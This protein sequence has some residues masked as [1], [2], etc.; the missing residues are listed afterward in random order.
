MKPRNFVR[1]EFPSFPANVGLARIAI[2]TFATQLEF[3][4]GELE[5]IRV[6]VSEAVSNCVIH[7]YPDSPG[8]VELEA[9][10]EDGCLEIGITDYGKGIDDIALARTPAFSTD[11][12]RMG[13]GLVFMESFMDSL[14]V[15]SEPGKGTR[16]RMRKKP[17]SECD[18]PRRV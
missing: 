11:P 6:A 5:E 14:E 12:E 18:G 10:I 1:L 16:I 17:E 9:V 13:L 4:L 15:Q 2:A 8:Q 7:A 3:T